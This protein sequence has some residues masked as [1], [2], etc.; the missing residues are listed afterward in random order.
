MLR[1][2]PPV[3]RERCKLASFGLGF[4][5]WSKMGRGAWSCVG[6]CRRIDGGCSPNQHDIVVR[7][8]GVAMVCCYGSLA[9]WRKREQ[10]PRWRSRR[11]GSGGDAG[12]FFDGSVD[13]FK[14][15]KILWVS[16][17]NSH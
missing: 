6:C 1:E 7:E 4:V 12:V 14:R 15:K 8:R 5:R 10:L 16:F 9:L 3:E 11:H 13:G 17:N 2:T